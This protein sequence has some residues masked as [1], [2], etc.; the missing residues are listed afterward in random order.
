MAP[1]FL[2]SKKRGLFSAAAV[3]EHQTILE[4]L[5]HNDDF[6]MLIKRYQDNLPRPKGVCSKSVTP[7]EPEELQIIAPQALLSYAKAYELI[8][9][10][11]PQE[12]PLSKHK[13]YLVNGEPQSTAYVLSLI[14]LKRYQQGRQPLLL[15]GISE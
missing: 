14:N 2:G 13:P 3:K 1:L 6:K 9:N 15:D 5:E 11:M 7:K 12:H 4:R 10:P 8:V